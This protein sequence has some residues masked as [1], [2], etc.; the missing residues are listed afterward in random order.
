[1]L[2]PIETNLMY[3]FKSENELSV[4]ILN[5][6]IRKLF[7]IAT[8]SSRKLQNHLNLMKLFYC[9]YCW[10]RLGGVFAVSVWTLPSRCQHQA[11]AAQSGYF[12]FSWQQ[13]RAGPGEPAHRTPPPPDTRRSRCPDT[14]RGRD[15]L[16]D[17]SW[18]IGTLVTV[19]MHTAFSE[20]ANTSLCHGCSNRI[21]INNFVEV[22]LSSICLVLCLNLNFVSDSSTLD[23]ASNETSQVTRRW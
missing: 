21:P 19:T 1:M 23:T 17:G 5:C 13:L 15:H 2:L 6:V 8:G 20:N 3:R 12:R 14:G 11:G 10:R 7:Y 9:R 22:I 16:T 4:D 18:H